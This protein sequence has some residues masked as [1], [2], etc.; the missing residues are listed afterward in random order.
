MSDI[1]ADFEHY[2]MVYKF[3]E[4]CEGLAFEFGWQV[5]LYRQPLGCGWQFGF[6]RRVNDDWEYCIS[7]SVIFFDKHP[8]E[9]EEFIADAR[10][11]LI[12]RKE[13]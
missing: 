2:Q 9:L 6:K 12:E 11:L 13:D 1:K 3:I 8:E 10:K 4:A 7:K 5:D